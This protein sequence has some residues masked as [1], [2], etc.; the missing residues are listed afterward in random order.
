LKRGFIPHGFLTRREVTLDAALALLAG[1]VI[2]VAEGCSK[3]SPTT[4]T[5]T[6]PA[7]INANISANHNHAVVIAGAQITAGNAFSVSILGTGTH[8]HTWTIS[9]ND[10][11]NLKNR[12]AITV[13][14]TTDNT[15]QHT[16]TFTPASPPASPLR[17]G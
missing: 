12:Q 3:K 15:H 1:C 4:P 9:Q 13:S 7:D 11:L 6:P 8:A 16:V 10:L 17:T 5:P 14:S 2:T